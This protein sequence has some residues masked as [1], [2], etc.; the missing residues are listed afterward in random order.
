MT[1]WLHTALFQLFKPD[2]SMGET[3]ARGPMEKCIRA[4]RA[5]LIVD[6]L[7]LNEDKSEFMLIGTCQQLSK[8]RTD[9]LMVGD[10]QVKSVSEARNL[11]VWFDSNFQFHSHINK[12]CQSA[13]FSLYK[14]RCI[15]IS[16]FWSCKV[17]SASFCCMQT[18][19]MQ[20][21]MVCLLYTLISFNAFK[22]SRQVTNQYTAYFYTLHLW[23]LTSIG[24]QL[25]LGSFHQILVNY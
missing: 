18:T 12:T 17:I 25:N 5:W 2:S 24:C 9:S 20:Y 3:E 6:K 10:T 8:V 11:G 23:W 4:V 19:V 15:K 21:Y 16:A 22:T 13:F 14:I 1:F 7:K